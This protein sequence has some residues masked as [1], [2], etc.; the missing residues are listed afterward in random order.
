[1]PKSTFAKVVGARGILGGPRGGNPGMDPWGDPQDCPQGLRVMGYGLWVMGHGFG[2]MGSA[3]APSLAQTCMDTG[4][5]GKEP[6]QEGQQ[7]ISNENT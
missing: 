1:M 7:L 4:P 2:I 5:K 6:Y 3:P